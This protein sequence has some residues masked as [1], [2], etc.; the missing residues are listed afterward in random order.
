MASTFPERG[1]GLAVASRYSASEREQL[2]AVARAS[3]EAGLESGRPMAVDPAAY[4][5][6]LQALRASFVTLRRRGELRGCVGDLVASH[7]LVVDV[8]EN[9]YRAAF[10]DR[11]FAPLRSHEL[12]G[13]EIHLSVLGPME[14]LPVAS[15]AELLEKLR[16]GVDGLT[17]SWGS[18]RATFLP[19]VWEGIPEPE[20]F[21]RELKRKAGLPGEMWSPEFALERYTAE[22]IE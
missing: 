20:R 22:S 15:E 13:L 4:P 21:V 7:P 16:P 19:S 11:R 10:R 17:L 12:H 14:P 9:A 5:A 1:S 18:L 6:A 2:L 8:S 3:I